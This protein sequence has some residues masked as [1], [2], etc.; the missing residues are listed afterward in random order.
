MIMT[1]PF[2]ALLFAAGASFGSFFYTL[3][4]RLHEKKTPYDLLVKR[5]ACVHCGSAIS[6]FRLIPVLGFFISRGKCPGC[7]KK[8]PVIYPVNEAVSGGL[9][10]LSF[11]HFGMSASTTF[12]ALLLIMGLALSITDVKT[13]Y[14]SGAALIIFFLLSIYPAVAMNGFKDSILGAF[15]LGSVFL[16]IM[17]VFP[18]SFGG[19]DFK[20][21]AV[22]GLLLGFRLSVVALE[23][24]LITGALTGI[25]YGIIT[26]KGLRIKIP[27][28]PF[29]YA[30]LLV[31]LF[32]GQ[33]ILLL[34]YNITD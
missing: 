34:Y 25:L 31:A 3:T 12:I 7:N 28:A 26:K 13:L 6:A 15:S 2:L 14:L 1:L 17:L 10:V 23:I 20:F 5:S 9:A 18:G 11:N 33:E 4:E 16:V 30:G 27:F 8:V 19:G 32:R 24:S 21:A 29:L 22:T